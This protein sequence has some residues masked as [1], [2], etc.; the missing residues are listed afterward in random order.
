MDDFI[1]LLLVFVIICTI[2][3]VIYISYINGIIVMGLICIALSL[4]V[5]V[6][7]AI[8]IFEKFFN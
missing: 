1:V 6:A 8:V 5:S 2:C 7:A 3:A 4:T